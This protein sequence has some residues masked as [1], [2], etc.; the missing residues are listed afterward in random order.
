MIGIPGAGKSIYAAK[1]VERVNGRLVSTDAIRKELTGDENCD[2]N[3][4]DRV[5]FI[6]RHRIAEYILDGDVVID[7]TNVHVRDWRKY[8]ELVPEGTVLK[9]Y[10]FEIPPAEALR[11][12]E[13]R[14]RKVPEEVIRRMWMAMSSNRKRLHD[15]FNEDCIQIIG[16]DDDERHEAT[17]EGKGRGDRGTEECPVVENV[18]GGKDVRQDVRN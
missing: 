18:E 8:R 13:Q 12:Q 5:Y 4:S 17:E 3:M 11:R 7:A 9:A 1:L 15:C 2:P 6:S 10:W 14:E 16:V